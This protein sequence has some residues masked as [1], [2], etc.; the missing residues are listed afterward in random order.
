MQT[1][2][3]VVSLIIALIIILLWTT[4]LGSTA[5]TFQGTVD[6]LVAQKALEACKLRAETSITGGDHYPDCDLDGY[7]D[8]CDNCIGG[9][10]T[11][12]RDGDGMADA[13]E[14]ERT[15]N[16]PKEIECRHVLEGSKNR[17]GAHKKCEDYTLEGSKCQES[18]NPNTFEFKVG[19]ECEDE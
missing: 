6:P 2:S 19:K 11:R 5:T 13:C 4:Q 12:D 3:V 7:P 10:S 18:D 15:R 1:S 9:D 8:F 14:T 16:D 17:C